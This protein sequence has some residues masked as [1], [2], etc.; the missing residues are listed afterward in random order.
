M[1]G[2]GGGREWR[3][4]GGTEEEEKREELEKPKEEEDEQEE[5]E[6]LEEEKQE[7]KEQEATLQV[8]GPPCTVEL[9]SNLP[10]G[11]ILQHRMTWR[12]SGVPQMD[13]TLDH[14]ASASQSNSSWGGTGRLSL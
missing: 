6:W 12:V 7:K 3:N 13:G 4:G 10:F 8:P 1:G 11:W 14:R 9:D 2:G 5:E